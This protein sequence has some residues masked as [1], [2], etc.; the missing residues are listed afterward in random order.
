MRVGIGYD[1]HRLVADRSL[2]IGGVNIP[3]DKG[4][5]GHSDADVLAHSIMDSLLGAMGM[6]D[7]GRHF[8]DTNEEFKGIS[9]IELLGQ[10]A[11]I[12]KREGYTIKNLDSI[13]MAQRPK[14]APYIDKMKMNISVALQMEPQYINIK[15]TTTEGLGFIGEGQGM[16]AKTV[17]LI[18]EGLQEQSRMGS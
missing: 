1:V 11:N 9:S 12:V 15:A 17:A 4:L 2:I 18:I 16:A 14:M 6:G 13:I 3:F 7:I 8:P 5:L 10:V